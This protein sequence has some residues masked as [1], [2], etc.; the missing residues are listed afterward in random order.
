MQLSYE[1]TLIIIGKRSDL[2]NKHH[3]I[4]VGLNSSQC[5]LSSIVLEKYGL[6]VSTSI[7]LL[8]QDITEAT[9]L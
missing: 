8:E 9:V 4:A 3:S 1:E 6:L 5:R 2:M 7:D